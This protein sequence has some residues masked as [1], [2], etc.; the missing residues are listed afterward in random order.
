VTNFGRVFTTITEAVAL[1]AAFP[2]F[3]EYSTH[4]ER[5]QAFS[6]AHKKARLKNE[7]GFLA[8]WFLLSNAT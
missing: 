6:P 8:L 3:S 1:Q 5:N 4:Q 7:A 2:L